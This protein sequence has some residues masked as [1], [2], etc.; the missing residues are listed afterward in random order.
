M[1][2]WF[3]AEIVFKTRDSCAI[4]AN[5]NEIKNKKFYDALLKSDARG[6]GKQEFFLCGLSD[7][8]S[9]LKTAIG[10]LFIAMN[11]KVKKPFENVFDISQIIT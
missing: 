11:R 3:N 1:R 5:F 8:F 2:D 6:D 7:I 9:V 4:C 10:V